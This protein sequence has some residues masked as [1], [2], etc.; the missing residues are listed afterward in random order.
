M[1]GEPNISSPSVQSRLMTTFHAQYVSIQRQQRLWWFRQNRHARRSGKKQYHGLLC[2]NM[3]GH[4]AASEYACVDSEPQYFEGKRGNS[5]DKLFYPAVSV[6]GSLP[7][8]PYENSK[9]ITCVVCS[10]WIKD[11]Y[12]WTFYTRFP[13]ISNVR[14]KFGNMNHKKYICI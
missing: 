13:F 5:D 7:C 3:Y 6:C 14:I 9:Y 4:P 12:L 11:L 1:Y 10:K 2:V 8:P